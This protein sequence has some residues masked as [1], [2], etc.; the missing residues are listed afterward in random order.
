MLSVP[1]ARKTSPSPRAA[2]A[3]AYVTTSIPEAQFRCT[4][5]AGTC[6]GIPTRTPMILETFIS[7]ASCPTQPKITSSISEGSTPVL[8]NT[9]LDALIP[10]AAPDSLAKSVPILQKGVR[11]PSTKYNLEHTA[12]WIIR[13]TTKI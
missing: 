10:R 5:T 1:P 13:D 11:L 7:L 3:A 12:I 8:T 6:S 9:F 2:L 4:V